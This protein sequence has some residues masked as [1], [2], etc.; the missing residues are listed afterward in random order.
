[1]A[2]TEELIVAA[3]VPVALAEETEAGGNPGAG[4]KTKKVKESKAKKASAP[5]KA[6]SAPSHPT[7]FEVR[8]ELLRIRILICLVEI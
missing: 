5:K 3:E 6:K 7:Y 4:G 2:A 8:I 1:M